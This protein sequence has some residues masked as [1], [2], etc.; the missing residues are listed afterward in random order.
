M[1]KSL[2]RIGSSVAARA[3]RRSA[4]EPPKWAS[5]VSTDITAAPPRSYAKHDLCP[6]LA[7]SRIEPAEGERRLCSAISEVPG[8]DRASANGRPSPLRG[9]TAALELG[10]ADARACAAPT[11]S[12]VASTRSSSRT[13]H[14]PPALALH[15][16]VQTV[17]AR[18]AGVDRLLGS[19]ASPSSR[20]PGP[21]ADV[22]RRAGVHHRSWERSVPAAAVQ[23]SSEALSAL[24]GGVARAPRRRRPRVRIPKFAGMHLRT[25]SNLLR[26]SARPRGWAR[27]PRT[28]QAHR[29]STLPGPFPFPRGP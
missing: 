22:D 9:S 17:S 25:R 3:S 27:P 5:S 20:V 1:V 14:A 18:G 21:A 29:R 11:A 24:P 19:A 15:V 13:A 6:T 28:H 23:D 7:P 10:Q 12:R 26:R 4:S 8:R 16:T 2:R